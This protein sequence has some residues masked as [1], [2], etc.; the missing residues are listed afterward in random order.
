MSDLALLKPE[1]VFNYFKEISAV[2]RGSQNMDGIAAYCMTFAEK[3]SLKAIRDRA[4]NV[5]IFKEG[6]PGYENAQPIILQGHLDIVCQKEEGCDINFLTDPISL[7]TDGDFVKAKGTTLGA[8]NGIAV[9]MILAILESKDIPH[10]PIEAVFT[11]DEEIG[12]IGALALDMSVLKGKQMINLD[13]EEDDALTVSCAGGSDFKVTVPLCR[14]TKRGNEIIITLKG[15]MGGHSGVEIN[16]GRMNANLLAGR[17]LNHMR[18]LSEFDIISIDGGDKGN[19]I[20]N[21][22]TIHLLVK[23]V[24]GFTEKAEEYL[25]VIKTEI[26]QREPDF[27]YSITHNDPKEHSVIIKEIQDKLIFSLLCVPNGVAE[28]SAEIKGLVETSLNLGILKTET[29]SATLLLTLRSN[30]KSAL[31]FLEEKLKAFFMPLSCFIE[32]SGHYPPWE[33]EENSSL[34]RLYKE[35]FL[36]QNG[37]EPKVEA[38]HA[39]LECG[40][41]ASAIEGLDCIAMGPQLFDVHTVNE[42]LSICSVDKTYKLLLKILEQCK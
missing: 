24:K 31:V 30:K 20:P 16:S 1:R 36:A 34:Q 32:T 28:M 4:D 38:I 23:E 35:C 7:Y 26:S 22:C 40:V 8:D 6:A 11:T 19:A 21:L 29:D 2:P 18:S 39:G 41:F 3:H 9:A 5:I 37:F 12:M 10:P 33:F 25:K 14:E 27:C 13:A 42:R 17:F 15:L